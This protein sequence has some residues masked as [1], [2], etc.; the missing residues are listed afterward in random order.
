LPADKLICV[1]V[2]AGAFGVR[3]EAKI[4]SFTQNPADALGYGP[5]LSEQGEVIITPQTHRP[6]KDGFAVTALEIKSREQAE[7]MK[8]TKLYVL[9][10]AFPAPE[11]DDFYYT[12]L[13]GLDVKSDAGQRAGTIIAVHEFGAGPMLEIQPSK[14]KKTGKTPA[15]FFHPFTKLAVPK[16]DLVAGRVI[17]HIAPTIDGRETKSD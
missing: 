15:S 16:V 11:E 13:I 5:L 4:K 3:G 2:I 12:D 9:R 10:S 8:S 17:I 6:V 1:A 7:A 14:D